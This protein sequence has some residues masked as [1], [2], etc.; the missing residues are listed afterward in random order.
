MPIWE[1]IDVLKHSEASDPPPLSV[2]KVGQM[3]VMTAHIMKMSLEALVARGLAEELPVPVEVPRSRDRTEKWYK[4]RVSN[5]VYCLSEYYGLNDVD[6]CR[7]EV[8]PQ[9]LQHIKIH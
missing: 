9:T 6:D 2:F 8:V 7:W 4:D 3:S 1:K 5:V